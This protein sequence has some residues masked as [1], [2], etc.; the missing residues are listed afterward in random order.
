MRAMRRECLSAV[1]LL[2][3]A[4]GRPGAAV[5]AVGDLA[6]GVSGGCYQIRDNA[7]AL[8]Q[9]ICDGQGGF[10]TGCSWNGALS[11]LYTTNFSADDLVV[12]DDADPHP[13][14]QTAATAPF[15]N[16]SIVFDAAGSF[17]VGHADGTRALEKYD[18]T[19]ALVASFAPATEDRGTDWNDLA[20]DQVTM[21]YTSEAESIKRFSVSGAGAQLADLATVAGESF[22]LRLLAPGDGSGGLLVANLG[23]VAKLDGAGNVVR[24]DALD[25]CLFS[26]N[27]DPNG[28]S[29]WA[30]D[31]CSSNVYKVNIATGAVETSFNTGTGTFTVFGICV[32]GEITAASGAQGRMTV[33]GTIAGTTVHHG[34]ELHCNA[35]A[36]P[37]NLEVSWGKS[38]HFHLGALTSARCSDDPSISSGAPAAAFDTFEGSGTGSF[39]G[40]GGYRVDFKF[41]DAGEPG[42]RDTAAIAITDPTG[43]KTV[44]S[45]SGA[46]GSGNHQAHQ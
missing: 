16:E 39:N 12:Y 43:T 11:K 41:T 5:W 29:Y 1:V 27:L 38:N 30:G 7:G 33:G 21:F 37:N 26:L 28:T 20:A 32:R 3:L 6:I 9:T 31:F 2:L 19:G 23:R 18:A 35:S 46:L 10:T 36:T 25:G 13:I 42:S 34:G 8:K 40:V 4:P 24:S 44:L 17:Y 45:A 15:S 14:L 22:A